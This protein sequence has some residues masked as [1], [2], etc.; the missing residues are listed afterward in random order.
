MLPLTPSVDG[1]SYA[2]SDVF[3]L[4]VCI[5]SAICKN[6]FQ[7]YVLDEGQDFHC[8]LSDAHA[9]MRFEELRELLL[10]TRP[11]RLDD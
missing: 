5:L 9:D 7:L 6:F 2:S 11:G 8:E 10:D 4:Q 3:Y 1:E